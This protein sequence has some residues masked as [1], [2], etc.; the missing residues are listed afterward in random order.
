MI[1]MIEPASVRQLADSIREI[2]K[3]VR[4]GIVTKC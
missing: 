1:K 2:P 3:Q 4:N